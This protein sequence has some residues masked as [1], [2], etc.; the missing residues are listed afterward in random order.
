MTATA[1]IHCFRRHRKPQNY[2]QKKIKL[3]IPF[4]NTVKILNTHSK[5]ISRYVYAIH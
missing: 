1:N 4:K 2:L 5:Y 3:K